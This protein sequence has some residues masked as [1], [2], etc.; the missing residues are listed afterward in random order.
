MKVL[1]IAFE[2]LP[3]GMLGCYG[4]EWI[5]TPAL[6]RLAGES[7]AFDGCRARRIDAPDAWSAWVGTGAPG[8]PTFLERLAQA[9]VETRLVV[10]V[11]E[12]SAVPVVPAGFLAVRTA[13]GADGLAVSET[14]AARVVDAALEDVAASSAAG[15]GSA[16]RDSLL[17]VQFRGP[18][19]RRLAPREWTGRYVRRF[20]ESDAVAAGEAP[21]PL[22]EA[23]FA[24]DEV[25]YEG[26]A[27]DAWDA[28]ADRDLRAAEPETETEDDA[29]ERD[30]GESDAPV[31]ADEEGEAVDRGEAWDSELD[32][33]DEA[34][35]RADDD[36]A[37]GTAEEQA[38]F[39]ELLRTLAEAAVRRPER[40]EADDWRL[41]RGLYGGLVAA[42]DRQV[43]RLLTELAGRP[44]W[45]DGLVIVTAAAGEFL[46]ERTAWRVERPVLREEL[47]RVPLL[48]RMPGGATFG[49]RAALVGPDDLGPTLCEAFG[50]IDTGTVSGDAGADLGGGTESASRSLLGV[51]RGIERDVRSMW[52]FTRGGVP[53]GVQ[54]HDWRWER[55]DAG[56][57]G[58]DRKVFSDKELCDESEAEG[59][60]ASGKLFAL[61]DDPYGLWDQAT[62]APDVARALAERC[63]GGA[64]G[65][66]GEET[67]K[68]S[69]AG[70]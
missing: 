68:R 32:F 27:Y 3:A 69:G 58:V 60:G 38:E 64:G 42:I 28:E 35:D 24:Q 34:A 54:T 6:D 15:Q 7:V 55:A 2:R 43:G 66:D 10:E 40:L 9:G 39:E 67:G 61:P 63:G 30:D 25:E 16:A 21:E 52:V 49:R 20:E 26:P 65:G 23:D 11:P 17:W 50:K 70:S 45:A 13:W 53:C 46:G 36:E 59:G 57:R 12:A 56:E 19:L 33:G 14:A 22:S 1:V 4:N 29:A 62:Q 5:E 37:L 18:D 47:L 44:E 51:V 41:V 48:V 8:S 31:A